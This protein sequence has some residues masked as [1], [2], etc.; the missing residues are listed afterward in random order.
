M[1]IG[2]DSVA[3]MVESKAARKVPNQILLITSNSSPV[4][5]SS[6]KGNSLA[7]GGKVPLV[8]GAASS[9]SPG[10]LCLPFC[11]SGLVSE[12]SWF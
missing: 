4:L 11:N 8:M 12:G 5:G 2:A 9:A 7:F 6:A 1:D 3:T 10:G